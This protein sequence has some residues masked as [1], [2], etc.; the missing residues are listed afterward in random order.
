VRGTSPLDNVDRLVGYRTLPDYGLV[1]ASGM[2]VSDVLEGWRKTA[3]GIGVLVTA[4][5]AGLFGLAVLALRGVAREQSILHGLEAAV[6]Q[7]TEEARAQAEQ[8]RLANESKTRFLAAASH[9]LRQPLQAAGMFTE[10]LA[11]RLDDPGNLAVVDKLRQSIEATNALLTTLLDVSALEAAR[12]QPT[13]KSFALWPLLSGLAGQYEP[14]ATARGLEIRVVPSRVRIV[15]DPVL[16]ERLLRNLLV[17]ALRY[18]DRGRVLLGCRRHGDRVAV[19]VADSGIGIPAD[20]LEAIFEDFT[21]LDTPGRPSKEANGLGLGLG[22]VRRMGALLGHPLTVRS[23]P[24]T[25]SVF[26]VVVPVA[27]A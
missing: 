8:A 25:G 13:I 15:S 3:L 24:G 5:L 26:G 10:A 6:Q 1:V 23:R 20:K 16:L 22:V 14:D 17:N 27:E 7:R 4:A 18:T 11:V 9:D 21:R 12:L 19:V 2:A